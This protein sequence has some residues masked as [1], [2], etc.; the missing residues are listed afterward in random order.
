MT[1]KQ[2]AGKIL[3][4]LYY[5]QTTIPVELRCERITFKLVPNQDSMFEATDKIGRA[6]E[7]LGLSENEL[8]NAFSYLL[9]KGFVTHTNSRCATQGSEYYCGPKPT[10]LGVDVIEGVERNDEEPKRAI[11]ALFNFEFKNNTVTVDSLLKAQVG[12][13]IGAGGKI[14][15]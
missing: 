5:M 7:K 2:A 12:D 3:L 9:E 13:I 6:F 10:A 1:T 14:S 11:K 8:Y 15:L 4:A